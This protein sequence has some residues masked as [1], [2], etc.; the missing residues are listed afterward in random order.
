VDQLRVSVENALEILA[1]EVTGSDEV[2]LSVDPIQPG[3]QKK[4][5]MCDNE[6]DS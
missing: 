6:I 1:V 4:T 3:N 2:L 5:M